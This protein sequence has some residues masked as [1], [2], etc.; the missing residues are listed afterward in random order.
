MAAKAV[1]PVLLDKSAAIFARPE[2]ATN[3]FFLECKHRPEVDKPK[4][5]FPPKPGIARTR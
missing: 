5:K 3:V 1:P 2:L 4:S